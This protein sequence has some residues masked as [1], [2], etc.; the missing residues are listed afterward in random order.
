[1][2]HTLHFHKG[3]CSSNNAKNRFET[4]WLVLFNKVFLGSNLSVSR[5]VI[6]IG[7]LDLISAMWIK[8]TGTLRFGMKLKFF[9][10]CINALDSPMKLTNI[11]SVFINKITKK[12]SIGRRSITIK[13]CVRLIQD[14]ETHKLG[15]NIAAQ[16]WD[17]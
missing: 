2:F 5:N 3:C 6:Q 8:R 1:M 4:W 16:Q 13:N 10:N 15:G 14:P 11:S 17:H 12:W 9:S 7:C